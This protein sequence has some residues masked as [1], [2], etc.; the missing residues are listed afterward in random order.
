MSSSLYEARVD[1][2]ACGSRVTFT[3]HGATSVKPTIREA[4]RAA[5]ESEKVHY[6]G[7]EQ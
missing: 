1:I 6:F 7:E 2:C 4:I 3:C 5:M